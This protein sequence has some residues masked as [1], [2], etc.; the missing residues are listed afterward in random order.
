[1]ENIIRT[2]NNSFFVNIKSVHFVGIG[3]ISL[4]ALARLTRAMGIN[5]TGSSIEE[6]KETVAVAK[7]GMIVHIGHNADNVPPD[8]DMLVY[9]GA[10]PETNPEIVRARQMRI[11]VVERSVYLGEIAK[12][13]DHV[14]A[15]AGSHGKTST[16]ALIGHIF[17]TA[18]LNPTI[19]IGGQSVSYGNLRIGSQR[20]FITE[21]CEYRE[22]M[23]YILPNT[24][25][26]SN[27]DNDHLDYYQTYDR[28]VHAFQRF[29]DSAS[30]HL[31]VGSGRKF[32]RVNRSAAMHSVGLSNK[33]D[34]YAKDIVSTKRGSSF[35]VINHGQDIGRF[36]IRQWGRHN[37]HNALYAIKV[38]KLY[39]ISDKIIRKALK[40][41]K[42]VERRYEYIG[43]Y[44]HIPVISDYAHHPTEIY[45]SIAG[46]KKHFHNVL[47]VFQPH[48]Y[49]RTRL[50]LRDFCT[51]F[52][53]ANSVIIYRTYP[54]RE[55][56]DQYGD[57]KTL[58]Q[59]LSVRNKY[60]AE[61]MAEL[62]QCIDVVLDVDDIDA[63]CYMGAGDLPLIAKYSKHR[64]NSR[65]S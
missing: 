1:M 41:F 23:K 33:Q 4:S 53:M 34:M 38:A 14:I 56:Y 55:E 57:E 58:Y 45:S 22:S 10:V 11:P 8:C 46:L 21:A 5:V 52:R 51:A 43:N 39:G 42:G 16:T 29:A 35:S 7:Q 20:F 36:E 15:I 25:V 48:T 59:A 62:A 63:I 30:D 47:V 27:V 37:V 31:I 6:N 32:R 9:S 28:V 40:T 12:L 49:S 44:R 60:V 54:A 50:L 24:C 18:K 26:I 17:V 64:F 13:Y 65:R 61:D 3:G 19:H 2:H